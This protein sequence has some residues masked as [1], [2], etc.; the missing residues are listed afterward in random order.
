MSIFTG[1]S[2]AADSCRGGRHE[3]WEHLTI[4]LGVRWGSLE[5]AVALNLNPINSLEQKCCR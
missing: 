4:D 2:Q 5:E 3:A 1:G